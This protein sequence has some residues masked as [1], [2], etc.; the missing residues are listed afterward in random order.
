MYFQYYKKCEYALWIDCCSCSSGGPRRRWGYLSVGNAPSMY[1][2][3]TAPCRKA[4]RVADFRGR[5]R[6]ETEMQPAMIPTATRVVF[7][8]LTRPESGSVVTA[9]KTCERNGQDGAFLASTA[10]REFMMDDITRIGGQPSTTTLARLKAPD[11]R[12]E[13]VSRKT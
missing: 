6:A 13:D 7:I 1:A 2:L 11:P 3:S 4:Y 12:G 8:I 9:T 5:G 10:Y